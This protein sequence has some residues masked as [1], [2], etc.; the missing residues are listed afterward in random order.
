[1]SQADQER[2][3][4]AYE[5]AMGEKRRGNDD[6][7]KGNYGSAIARYT[8]AV[9]NSSKNLGLLLSLF[10]NRAIALLR[11]KEYTTS[12]EDCRM[13][14]TLDENCIKAFVCRGFAN[15]FLLRF[16]KS[17]E[18]FAKVLSLQPDNKFLQ[19]NVLKAKQTIAEHK[20][21]HPANSKKEP[22][23]IGEFGLLQIDEEDY[24]P[25][26][27]KSQPSV[28]KKVEAPP[29][30]EEKKKEDLSD[31]PLLVPIGEFVGYEPIYLLTPKDDA[32][33]QTAN[34]QKLAGNKA[35]TLGNYA[36]ALRHYSEAIR[37]NSQE[38]VFYANRALVYLKLNRQVEAITDCTSALERQPRN[39]KA[40]LR[41]AAAWAS[42]SEYYPA[43]EDYKKAL[44][45]EPKNQV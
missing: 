42:L 22:P 5:L 34:D 14:L 35:F 13:C 45:I 3:L 38:S 26:F 25:S 4:A 37:W 30:V 28:Q 12:I 9:A 44:K 2:Y 23:W 31:L 11:S 17:M 32:A 27:I 39:T 16:D 29:S 1:M 15:F 10:T 6:L 40:Y 21:S 8:K 41:R 18:D 43:V 19:K 20:A 33:I 7:K 24:A 36:A